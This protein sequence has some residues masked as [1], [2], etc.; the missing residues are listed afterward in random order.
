MST[1]AYQ[2]TG[3]SFV[4][5]AVCSGTD[6]KKKS[7]L[8]VT[9]LCEGNS[10]VTG[11]FP[12]QRA[13]NAENVSIWWR[14]YDRSSD[15]PISTLQRL[16]HFRNSHVNISTLDNNSLQT[17]I[18]IGWSHS[19]QPSRWHVR[20]NS[21]QLTSISRLTLVFLSNP[22]SVFYLCLR[23]VL[24]SKN[25]VSYLAKTVWFSVTVLATRS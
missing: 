1:M 23:T 24:D 9:G 4:Y 10:L 11:E 20:E 14:H 2:I 21:R 7:K 8:C 16:N 18:P 13:Y 12:T 5:S 17:W 3:V 19:R 15:A 6:Q 25:L 22:G